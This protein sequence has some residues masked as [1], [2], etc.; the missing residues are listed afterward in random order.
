MFHQ[1]LLTTAVAFVGLTTVTALGNAR[2]S[3]SCDAACRSDALGFLVG[4]CPSKLLANGCIDGVAAQASTFCSAFLTPTTVVV[5][6]LVTTTT[7]VTTT[8]TTTTVTTATDLETTTLTSATS[9]STITTYVPPPTPAGPARRAAPTACPELSTPRL[10]RLSPSKVSSLCSL[11]GVT[12]PT[13]TSTSTGTTTAT[14]T[15]L[16]LETALS[17]TTTTT[18]TT[19]TTSTLATATVV[20]DYCDQRASYRPGVDNSETDAIEQTPAASAEECC[21]ACWAKNN[22]VASAWAGDSTCRHLIK[23]QQQPGVPTSEQCPLGI[24]DYPY[25]PGPGNVYRGPCSPPA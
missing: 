12:P 24:E 13:T 22:C 2:P 6:S 9:T 19:T 20:I 10:Q 3:P 21:R 23:F 14:S 4:R 1:S 5:A 7:T 16:T 11:L 15:S 17:Q 25:Q 8:S 18:T